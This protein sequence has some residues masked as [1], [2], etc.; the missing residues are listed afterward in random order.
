MDLKKEI[1]QRSGKRSVPQIFIDARSVG[2]LH[3]SSQL[4]AKGAL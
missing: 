2:G 3:E 4:H 1:I